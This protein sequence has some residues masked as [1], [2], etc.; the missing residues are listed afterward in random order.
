MP[1]KVSKQN[2]NTAFN[3]TIAIADYEANPQYFYRNFWEGRTYE[4]LSE[5]HALD[6]WLKRIIRTYN[7]AYRYRFVLDLGGGFGRLLP[8]LGQYARNVVLGDYSLK[9]IKSGA[10]I[11]NQVI[12]QGVE[13]SFV[14]LNAYYLPFRQNSFDIVVSFRLLHHI[15][16]VDK[17]LQEVF[18]VIYPGGYMV[19]EF[20]HKNH[21]KAVIRA[22]LTGNFSF[23]KKSVIKQKHNPQ[24]AQGLKDPTKDNILFFNYALSYVVEQA[25]KAGF[26]VV[27]AQPVSFLRVPL[28]KRIL[29]YKTLLKLERLLQM[30]RFL[31]IT[32]SIVL[33]LQKPAAIEYV[34]RFNDTIYD[35]LRCPQ[36]R[37]KILINGKQLICKKGHSYSFVEFEGFKIFD[38][39]YPKK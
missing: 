32:P 29:G 6:K 19:L 37:G 30:F 5:V 1:Q 18:R 12:K 11:Y 22:L 23:F 7:V 10:D 21:I 17:L 8:I 36:D 33:V 14:G 39:R 28:L 3:D 16:H 9:E 34:R 4:H 35:I 2:N 27:G 25:R 26:N 38:M 24:T 20:A 31:R 15:T 13:P